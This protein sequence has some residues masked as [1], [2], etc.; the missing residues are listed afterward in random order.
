MSETWTIN[1]GSRVY[2][3]YNA[4]QMQI[5]R[6]QGRL[7]NHSLVAR[8]GEDNFRPAAED[9]SL[10]PLFATLAAP[11]P[12]PAAV[13]PEQSAKFGREIENTESEVNRYVIVADMKSGS[14][15]AVEGEINKLG[16]ACRL[17]TQTW[18]LN[19]EISLNTLRSALTQK[20][21]KLDNL[22]IVDVTHDKAAWFNFG[23]ETETR[24]RGMW[25]RHDQRKAG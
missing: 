14:I 16:P 2:G 10:A 18:L 21:G 12:E 1:A 19:S 3:P 15:A 23:P 11:F 24:L 8:T 13:K 4:E 22:L 7:A 5:F 6:D 9:Q 17:T 20:L 25:M